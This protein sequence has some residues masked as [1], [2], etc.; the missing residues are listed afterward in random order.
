VLNGGTEVVVDVEEC[1][2]G[3]VGTEVVD[4]GSGVWGW[5]ERRVAAEWEC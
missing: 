3:G 5:R 2:W 4:G 1:T